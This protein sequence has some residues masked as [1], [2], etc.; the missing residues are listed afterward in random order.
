M[1]A[2]RYPE[3]LSSPHCMHV[4]LM[5]PESLAAPTHIGM[6]TGQFRLWYEVEGVAF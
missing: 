3:T 4:V 2:Q 5:A 6:L 1:G